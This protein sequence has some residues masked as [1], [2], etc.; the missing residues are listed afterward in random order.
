MKILHTLF[1]EYNHTKL[2]LEITEN[3]RH[4]QIFV[5]KV[6]KPQ[7]YWKKIAAFSH[8]E[9]TISLHAVVRHHEKRIRQIEDLLRKN[10]Q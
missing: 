8:E 2:K 10:G 1:S 5:L 6:W 4:K 3:S 7:G 9:Q